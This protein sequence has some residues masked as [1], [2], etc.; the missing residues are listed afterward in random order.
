MYTD[1]PTTSSC[2]QTLE[3][4][5]TDSIQLG[6]AVQHMTGPWNTST[7]HNFLLQPPT[8]SP[9]FPQIHYR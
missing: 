4:D 1:Q 7:L 5:F 8:V 6:M 2:T 3:N 9:W